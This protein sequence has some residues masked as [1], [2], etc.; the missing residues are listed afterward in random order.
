DKTG[1][2]PFTIWQWSSNHDARE[3]VEIVRLLQERGV[4][5][6]EPVLL[7]PPPP[8]DCGLTDSPYGLARVD[9]I[10]LHPPDESVAPGKRT[11]LF[12]DSSERLY[13][14]WTGH[15]WPVVVCAYKKGEPIDAIPLDQ[16][17]LRPDEISFLLWIPAG[18]EY[19][20]RVFDRHG[21]L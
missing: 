19:Q 1:I 17:M 8:L 12:S 20:I 14:I 16:V 21:L 13:G 7:M 4:S 18:V 5:F 6:K 10:V 9:A 2:E 11:V 3:Y 15:L